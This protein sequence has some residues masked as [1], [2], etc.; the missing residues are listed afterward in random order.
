MCDQT[1][2]IGALRTIEYRPLKSIID[3]VAAKHRMN[4]LRGTAKV[5]TE[6]DPDGEGGQN[7]AYILVTPQISRSSA[8]FC[9]I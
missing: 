8:N 7:G 5:I 9:R 1:D 4:T 2:F 6:I 3:I